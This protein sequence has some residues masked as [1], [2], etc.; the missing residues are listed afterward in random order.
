MEL[1]SSTIYINA[2]LSCIDLG[3]IEQAMSEINHSDIQSLHYDIVDG[4]FNECF[5]F[6]DLMLSVFH[7]YTNLPITVHLAC[8]NP[9]PYLQPVIRNGANYI[10]VHYEAHIDIQEVFQQIRNLGAKPVLAFRCNSEV[11]KNFIALAKEA[12]WILKLTVHPGFA[13]QPFYQDALQHIQE[14]HDRL[15]QAGIDK[16]IE[17]DG[18]IHAGT[19]GACAKAGAT[20]FTGGSSGLFQ[21]PHSLNENIAILK[22]AIIK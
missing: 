17:V 8:Q 2:S 13:G 12:E 11:P 14:M 3:H 4:H 7:R 18:N 1:N 22:Q 6:G 21:H 5:I 10:A 19:I 15:E 20:M 9:F 16:I